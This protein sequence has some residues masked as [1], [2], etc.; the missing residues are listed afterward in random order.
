[1]SLLLLSFLLFLLFL[2]VFVAD[3]VFVVIVVF[4]VLVGLSCSSS[5]CCVGF[6]FVLLPFLLQ[7]KK[8][9]RF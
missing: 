7:L 3:F 1:M 2:V 4:G 8:W 6:D 9:F 5:G